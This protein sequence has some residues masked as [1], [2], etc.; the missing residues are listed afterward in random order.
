MS[1]ARRRQREEAGADIPRRERARQTTDGRQEQVARHRRS[2]RERRR[3]T[4]TF[5]SVSRPDSLLLFRQLSACRPTAA[6]RIGSTRSSETGGCPRTT[7]PAQNTL[8]PGRGQQ[9]Q[10][11]RERDDKQLLH[12]RGGGGGLWGVDASSGVSSS[13]ARASAGRCVCVCVCSVVCLAA[14]EDSFRDEPGVE[15]RGKTYGRS[16]T[17]AAQWRISERNAPAPTKSAS[18]PTTRADLRRLR[19]RRAA[20]INSS[21][22]DPTSRCPFAPSSPRP[23]PH[24]HAH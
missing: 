8:T 2:R 23:P 5:D 18:A 13:R 10:H 17:A 24:T 15:A 9:Q 21:C 4:T 7:L 19:R 14:R 11:G 6:M 3:K 22:A 16:P 20:M 1:A 12:H